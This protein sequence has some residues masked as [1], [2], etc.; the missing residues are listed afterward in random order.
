MTIT[1]THSLDSINAVQRCPRC[2][3]TNQRLDAGVHLVETFIETVP[4]Y[5]VPGCVE[6][7]CI[8]GERYWSVS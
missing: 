4:V 5:C 7:R 6:E 3:H 1:R 2:G 8:D